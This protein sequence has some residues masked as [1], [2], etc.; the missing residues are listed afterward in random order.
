ML[1]SKTILSPWQF[2]TISA[3]QG[4]LTLSSFL[5]REWQLVFVT[6]PRFRCFLFESHSFRIFRWCNPIISG[7]AP[8]HFP[9][10]FLGHAFPSAA[11]LCLSAT[12]QTVSSTHIFF[13]HP[14]LTLYFFHF[15]SPFHSVFHL[16]FTLF[17]II[18]FHF[19]LLIISSS[20]RRSITFPLLPSCLERSPISSEPLLIPFITFP[21]F[22]SLSLVLFD[23]LCN[24][25]ERKEEEEEEKKR[26][27]IYHK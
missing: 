18:S 24:C 20:F 2:G 14:L 8:H 19:S 22:H 27:P 1:L 9:V 13:S 10:N 5:W 21:I 4:S 16:S 3:S 17:Q 11:F 6:N 15:P 26:F 23:L 12:I 7:H 25:R